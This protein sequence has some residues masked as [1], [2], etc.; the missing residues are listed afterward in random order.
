[1]RQTTSMALFVASFLSAQAMAER[2]RIGLV[3]SG[4]G[5][6]GA[7]HIGVLKVLEE[8]HVPVDVIVGT[9]MGSI[10]GAM[11]AT[12]LTAEEV[13]RTV[14]TVDWGS[15]FFD[16]AAR[17]DTVYR[18]KND[19]DVLA[20]RVHIGLKGM[21]PAFPL[22]FIQGQKVELI[23]R[24]A[25]RHAAL[26]ENFD[27][28]PIRF[29]AVA[30]DLETGELVVIGSGD[31][32]LAIRASLAVPG[33]FAP[34]EHDGRLLVDGMVAANLPIS[35]M[36]DKFDVDAIIAVDV[37]DR[38][39]TRKEIGSPLDV[40]AQA[41]T[42]MGRQQAQ[43]QIALL[44]P[45]DTLIQPELGTFSSIRFDEA[46]TAIGTGVTAT[47]AVADRLAKLSIPEQEYERWQRER[48]SML[49]I[50]PPVIR[51]I[52]IETDSILKPELLSSR[53]SQKPAEV[54]DIDRL[55][56]D[57]QSIQSYNRFE[58]V[59]YSL[60]P[61]EDGQADLLVHLRRRS[62]GPDFLRFGFT[63][64]SDFRHTSTFALSL[65][66]NLISLSRSGGELR[67][68]LRLGQDPLFRMEYVQPLDRRLFVATSAGWAR[69]TKPFQF[70]GIPAP[71]RISQDLATIRLDLGREL[72]TWGE[73]R[74]GI[75]RAF[76]Q[77]EALDFQI[78]GSEDYAKV[79]VDFG[80]D[81][82]DDAN[83]PKG[84]S[85]IDLEYHKDLEHLGG[86]FAADVFSFAA[87]RAFSSGRNRLIARA[88]AGMTLQEN[89]D[90]T[91]FEIGGFA[92]LS[93][94][95]DQ[96]LIGKYL[97]LASMTYM[98]ELHGGTRSPL[99]MPIYV[100]AGL[101]V[102]NAWRDRGDVSLSS[103]LKHGLVF[104]GIESLVGP[105]YLGYGFAQRGKGNVYLVIGSPF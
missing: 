34:V 90:V 94:L 4:G 100:G 68:D 79:H 39:K 38:P 64:R 47:R 29:R 91:P 57:L 97:G 12:G 93:G 42:L 36:L 96:R 70:E 45:E 55:D 104:F 82:L 3:L 86:D 35:V 75:S 103:T 37:G 101:E 50:P 92:R 87:H 51:S 9:S 17:R 33:A 95:G 58:R 74:F 15:A 23:L 22:G 32:F 60:T 46:A 31:I 105:I 52:S 71:V 53:I 65:Q 8:L 48:R 77:M 56:E 84:G 89:A 102:G 73:L 44:R 24:K 43:A 88:E 99:D 41:V 5:A 25:T 76:A 19:D 14:N 62:W 59:G 40:V 72:G 27:D 49:E 18:H 2:P 80:L 28:F 16:T 13:E 10:V 11:Y 7:A 78:R 69:S 54:L 66:H 61:V 6:R 85:V 21:K 63:V 67:S 30:S 98:R 1:M 26:A 83:F 81:T 20:G